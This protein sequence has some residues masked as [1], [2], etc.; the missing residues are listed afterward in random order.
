M[1]LFTPLQ[2]LK[3]DIANSFG[4]DKENWDTRLDWFHENE[5]NL[6][7]L[8]T[9]ADEPSMFYAGVQAYKKVLKGLPIGYP[10][11]LD[12]TSSG[13]QLL[14]CVTGCLKSAQMCNVVD[15]GNRKDSY[16]DIYHIMQEKGRIEGG[17]DRSGV[18]QAIMTALYSS[19]AIPIQIFGEDNVKLFY[20]TMS[21]EVPGAWA[22]NEA[23]L[24]M[25]NPNIDTYRWVM[26]DNFNV[27]IKVIDSVKESFDFLGKERVIF[28]KVHQPTK[29]GRSLGAN[30]IHSID[31][32]VVREL[33]GRCNYNKE[34]IESIKAML[35]NSPFKTLDVY[36]ED[37]HMVNT[38]WDLYRSSKFLS[39]RILD[40]IN[41]RTI[42]LVDP[43]IILNLINSLPS[44]PF[45]VL[46]IHDCFRVLPLYGN[47]LRIQINE[48][49]ACIVESEIL[50]FLV[51][52]LLGKYT[53]VVKG[54]L[55][56]DMVREAN[57]ILS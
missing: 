18:K 55:T 51:S 4:L 47:D 2:Y 8:M 43:T 44:K 12:A 17:I 24:N 9:E 57:Y 30:T 28:R 3:I 1:Q 45:Q 32:M 10:I 31:G 20:Q 22:L 16:T 14:A 26:P 23:F 49:Y 39:V 52:Q 50:S 29:E 54:E 15:V 48:I 42:K 21:E 19:K 25:W 34:R 53:P 37:T 46:T 38:L 6:E 41:H 5:H 13:M 27:Q 11:S 7:N 56:G 33:V 36:D 35:E 40:H